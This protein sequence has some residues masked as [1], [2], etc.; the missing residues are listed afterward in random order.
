MSEGTKSNV[1]EV[2]KVLN[3]NNTT[4]SSVE[5]EKIPHLDDFTYKVTLQCKEEDL[6]KNF[7]KALAEVSDRSRHIDIKFENGSVILRV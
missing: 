3:D 4:R 5:V 7:I 6:T 2:K 1:E